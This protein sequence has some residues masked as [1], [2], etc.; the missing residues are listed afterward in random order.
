[1]TKLREE[2]RGWFNQI[3]AE[4]VGVEPIFSTIYKSIA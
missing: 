1:M 4:E 2:A 3:V